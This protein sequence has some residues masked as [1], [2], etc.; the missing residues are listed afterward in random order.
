MDLSLAEG[1][2]DSKQ[3]I[4]INNPFKIVAGPGAGKTTFLVNHIRNIIENSNKISVLRKIACITYTNVGADSIISKLG[5]A[6]ESTEVSTIHSFLYK[7][8]VKPYL[9]VLKDEYEFDFKNIKGHDEIKPTYSILNQWKNLS[10]QYLFKDKD[11]KKLSIALS[12]LTWTMVK[13]NFEL[14]LPNISYSKIGKYYIKK[15]SYIEY[16]KI[17]WEKGL[18]S[19][20]DILYL[21]YKI[22]KKNKRILDIIRS[23]F[24][25]ILVDEFQDTNPIQTKIIKLI[26]KEESIIGVIGDDC[27]SIYGFQGAEVKQ[28]VDFDLE[29]MKLYTINDNRRST[30]EIIDLLNYMRK[31]YSIKQKSPE[32][33]H[34]RKPLILIGNI[35]QSYQ[36]VIELANEESVYTLSYKKD[37][38]K[39][40][41]YGVDSLFL[42]K[43]VTSE[44]LFNDS[45]RGQMI[46]YIISSIEYSRQK[47]YKEAIKC[48]KKA[49]RKTEDFSDKNAIENI[50]RLLENY[51]KIHNLNIKEF[52]NDYIYNYYKTKRKITSGVKDKY[53]KNIK[54]NQVASMININD[55]L[56]KYRTIH[57]AKGEEFTNVLVLIDPVDFDE[58][59]DLSFLLLPDMTKE[60]HRVYY[61]A[62][63]RAKKR[64]FI[65]IPQVSDMTKK[66]LRALPY[67]DVCSL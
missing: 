19:H 14:H 45:E 28:F 4:D 46:F 50:K 66:W 16:K 40:I 51:S 21:S 37:V 49:Y 17:C 29:N 15:K 47:N 59:K 3:K 58:S 6:Y 56:S 26:A 12:K 9:W 1:L 32:K 22:I 38:S 54:Y 36:K 11:N 61:V 10:K 8:V 55:D 35:I 57:K 62:C 5:D 41:E 44:L 39:K 7:H 31:E 27:Q 52:Y 43:E 63:S 34:G 64:L 18:L 60:E 24:P 2:K 20:D 48:M 13:N 53:Y 42:D 33:L 30:I 25:Y 65:S 23:K 67:F